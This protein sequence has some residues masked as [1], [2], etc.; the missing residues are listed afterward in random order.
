M[1]CGCGKGTKYEVTRGDGKTVTV[2]SLA[3]AKAI[4]ASFGGTYR[5]K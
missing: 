1:G 5:T 3:E 4:T 2:N